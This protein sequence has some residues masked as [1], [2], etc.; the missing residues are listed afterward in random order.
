MKTAIVCQAISEYNMLEIN[1]G[2]HNMLTPKHTSYF[3]GFIPLPENPLTLFLPIKT[4][5]DVF[6]VKSN[7]N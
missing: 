6:K 7:L 4:I 1:S 3:Y 5:L 2:K